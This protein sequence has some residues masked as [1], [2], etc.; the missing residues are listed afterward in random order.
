MNLKL[1]KYSILSLL[2]IFNSSLIGTFIKFD[3]RWYVYLFILASSTLLYSLFS[4][5]LLFNKLLTKKNK[6]YD[7]QRELNG[8]NYVYLVPCYNESYYELINTFVSILYQKKSVYDNRTLIVVCDGMVIG[9]NNNKYTNE[10]LLEIFNNKNTPECYEY[11]TREGNL[12]K[13]TK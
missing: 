11:Y 5:V 13:Y 12:N 6:N 3:Y 10:I 8:I 2:F 1:Q 7:I 9:K 4:I